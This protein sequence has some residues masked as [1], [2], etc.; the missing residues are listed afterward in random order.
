MKKSLILFLNFLV[1]FAFCEN[2]RQKASIQDSLK[3]H[4]LGNSINGAIA[5]CA[6]SAF[7]APFGL[8]INLTIIKNIAPNTPISQ[9]SGEKHVKNCL[10]TQLFQVFYIFKKY[11]SAYL[12]PHGVGFF[13]AKQFTYKKLVKI[14][15]LF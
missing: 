7:I 2:N 12:I 9:L 15:N 5:I 14:Y 8:F 1:F 13:I 3:K 11:D 4:L 6:T 10:L